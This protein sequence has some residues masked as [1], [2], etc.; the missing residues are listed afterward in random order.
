[1][2]PIINGITELNDSSLLIVNSMFSYCF[3][4]CNEYLHKTHLV[5]MDYEGQV[6]QQNLIDT[7]VYFFNST[8]YEDSNW[9]YLYSYS[10]TTSGINKN[11]LS[12]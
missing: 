7:A 8:M 10:N 12:Y 9:V 6:L 3:W 2:P 11:D 5:R 1:M 4:F